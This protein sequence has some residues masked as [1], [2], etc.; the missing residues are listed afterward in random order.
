MRM[1]NK[2]LWLVILILSATSFAY[3][4]EDLVPGSRYT[5][6]R[7]AAMGDAYLPLPDNGAEG[8]FYNPAGLAHIKAGY[9]SEPINILF[10]GGSG[11]MGSLGTGTAK[12]VNL[13]NFASTLKQDETMLGSGLVQALPT[14]YIRGFALG[15]LAKAYQGA[16]YNGDGYHYRT[17]YELVPSA[18]IGFN[19]AHG[20]V[21]VGYSFQWVHKNVVNRTTTASDAVPTWREKLKQGSAMSH[22][23]GY[24]LTFPIYLLPQI[25]IVAR[26]IGGAHYNQFSFVRLGGA[27]NGAPETDPMTVDVSFSIKPKVGGGV[28]FNLVAEGRD[29]LRRSMATWAA[30]ACL[31]L[32]LS[33]NERV[34]IRGGWGSGYPAGGIG[35][36]GKST[37]FSITYSTEEWGTGYHSQ[38]DTKYMVQYQIRPF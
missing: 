31:G 11:L 25:N 6:A 20:I 8:L 37:E 12:F 29:V 16:M 38:A 21:R 10:A 9:H 34:Y 23:L 4:R 19:L 36:R 27:A 2:P 28:A 30:R 1:G 13:Q 7:A 15:V 35:I 26:N 17:R 33:F 5:S 32:E 3:A 24:A 18:G 22:N 14:L